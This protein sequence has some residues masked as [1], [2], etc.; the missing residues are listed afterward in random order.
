MGQK[1]YYDPKHG[2]CLRM[3]TRVDK[4]TSMIKGA[5]GDDE[6]LKGFWFAKIE[7][8]SENKEIDGKQYN[9]IV[10]FEM[11]KELAHKRKLYAYMGSN[12]KIRWEDGNVWLQMYWA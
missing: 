4:T 7:H 2:W 12:R 11:K 10:D 8:L 6:E 9:M 5:Y 3:V 1:Y